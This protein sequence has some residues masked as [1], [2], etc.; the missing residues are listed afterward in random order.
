MTDIKLKYNPYTKEKTLEING[1][2][3]DRN[4][5]MN[6]CGADGSELSEWCTKFFENILN[7]EN[8]SFTVHF[9][10]IQRD[11]EFMEDGLEKFKTNHSD[12]D[13]NL[14]PENIVVA[15]DRLNEL[16]DLFNKMQAETPFEQ[17]KGQDLKDLFEQ[18]TNSDFEMAV[19]ATMSSGKSTLINS[20][21][22]QELLPARNEATT[23]T[24]AKIHDIDGSDHFSG[25][26]Y[27][28]DGNELAKCDPLTVENM[29]QLNNIDLAP[30]SRI[31][32]YGDIP[33][34]ESK[35]IQLVLTDTPGPN[36]SRTSEHQKH[37]MDLL[38]A[39]YKPMIIYVLNGTQLE[40]NDDSLLLSSVAKIIK[41]GDRQ[42]R[43]R[44]LFVL[45]K[46]DEFDPEKDET[47]S[48]KID[49]V[50]RYLSEKHGITNPRVFPTAARLAK[51]IRQ[52]INNDPNLTSKDKREVMINMGGF[53]DDERLHFSDYADFL[54]PSTFDELKERIAKAKEAG[55]ENEEAL[56]YTGVP[57]IEMA[58][59]EYLTKYALPAKISEGVYSFKDKIDALNVEAEEKNKLAGNESK[60]AELQSQLDHIKSVLSRGEKA[61]DVKA[62]IENLSTENELKNALNKARA[63]FLANFTKR[64]QNMN[65]SKISVET[66]IA[67]QDNLRLII[68][69]I[70]ADFTSLIEKS[71]NEVLR[72]QAE[73]CVKS[74]KQYVEDLIGSVGYE[75]PPAAIL[76]DVATIS[77]DET[78][79][80][81]SYTEDVVVGSHKVKNEG[82]RSGVARL[83]NLDSFFG[84]EGYH[85]EYEYETEEYVN[86]SE[87]IKGSLYPQIVMF[88]KETRDIATS[89]AKNTEISFKKFFL[90]KLLELDDAIK[91]KIEEQEKALADQKHFTEMIEQNKKN[92]SW[93]NEFKQELDNILTV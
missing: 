88:E 65:K 25:T 62:Q 72:S 67:Y 19:V 90:E 1:I 46:A 35:N 80:S 54:S 11:Y 43:D 18:A 23:A 33:G 5:T 10:G 74:Y 61:S 68:P 40:T 86:F 28:A 21:L 17:L 24:I 71:L 83:F 93:L 29:E 50:K 77:V 89:W 3:Q 8:D 47:V 34:I 30:T 39:D 84:K 56:I 91:A 92:L 73:S 55:D 51:Q 6:I 58:I 14:I 44:F 85:T 37:T 20:I 48:R 7:K 76:G 57:S 79:N 53:I 81:Y 78:L 9:S 60:V 36:N 22:G 15:A 45:N 38:N 82:F 75:L 52:T 87:F 66:A 31:E 16:K 41:S 27:D 32:I 13:S 42:S 63:N 59:T 49:D 2:S 4:L 69:T 12:I 64:T 26:S 70:T